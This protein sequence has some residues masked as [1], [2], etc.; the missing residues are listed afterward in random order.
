MNFKETVYFSKK[1]AKLMYFCSFNDDFSH[2]FYNT[3]KCTLSGD[4]IKILQHLLGKF[5]ESKGFDMTWIY[6][7]KN[8]NRYIKDALS[9]L[10]EMQHSLFSKFKPSQ[11]IYNAYDVFSS[12][13]LDY[14][15]SLSDESYLKMLN[16][17]FDFFELL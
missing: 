7:N 14:K 9:D 11:D 10:Y 3:M 16:S 8:F 12:A 1:L 6:D 4:D 17:F 15:I 13:K 5:G 2:F